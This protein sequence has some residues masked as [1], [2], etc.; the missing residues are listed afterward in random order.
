LRWRFSFSTWGGGDRELKLLVNPQD[1]SRLVVFDTW[2]MN[3]DRHCPIDPGTGIRRKPNRDNV[4]L[5]EDA[6]DGQFLLKA[7]DHTHCFSCG[8][9]WTKRLNQFDRIKDGR[10]FGLFPGVSG[11]SDQGSCGPGSHRPGRDLG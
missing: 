5:S 10:V 4:F 9:D 11:F 2:V 8:R 6:P 3:C 1:I 7:I